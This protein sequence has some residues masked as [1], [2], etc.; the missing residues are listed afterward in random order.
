MSQESSKAQLAGS[1]RVPHQGKVT[2]T[3]RTV[4]QSAPV[5]TKETVDPRRRDC[6]G[7]V[8]DLTDNEMGSEQNTCLYHV[9][10]IAQVGQS[11]VLVHA[12]GKQ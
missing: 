2:V 12:E 7:V 10:V 3:P 11:A 5:G 6:V 1:D 9:Q 4:H 8:L